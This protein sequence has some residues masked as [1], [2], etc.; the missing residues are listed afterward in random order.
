MKKYCIGLIVCS[1][2]FLLISFRTKEDFL[3]ILQ[4]KLSTYYAAHVP[5]KAHLFLNQPG[6]IPGDTLYYRIMLVQSQG[7][8]YIKGRQIVHLQFVNPSN[9]IAYQATVPVTDGIGS[10]QLRLPANLPPGGYSVLVYHNVMR[11]SKPVHLFQQPLVIHNKTTHT[12]SKTNKPEFFV[13]SGKLIA[14]VSN[15]MV[16][17]ASPMSTIRISDEA[18]EILATATCDN[19][20]W[21]N[22]YF[23]PSSGAKYYYDINQQARIELPVRSEEG[24]SMLVSGVNSGDHIRVAVQSSPETKPDESYVLVLSRLDQIFYGA[25]VDL[26]NKKSQVVSFAKKDLERGAYAITLFAESGEIISERLIFM[27]KDV[28]GL[29]ATVDKS[30]YSIREKVTV[31]FSLPQAT[32]SR[33]AVTV[34]QQDLFD[35]LQKYSVDLPAYLDFPSIQGASDFDTDRFMITQGQLTPWEEVWA[36]H[37]KSEFGFEPFLRLTGKASI[38]ST[39]APV[40]D[41]TRIEFFLQNDAAGYEFHTDANGHFSFPLLFDFYGDEQIH[42]FAESNGFTLQNILIE[43]EV[44]RF[45]INAHQWVNTSV[46]DPYYEFSHRRQSIIQSYYRTKPVVTE[47]PQWLNKRIEEAM[48]NADIEIKLSDYVLFPTMHETLLEI[49][50]DVKSRVNKNIVRVALKDENHDAPEDPLYII[51]GVLTD[52]SAY[53]LSLNPRDVVT[54]KVINTRQKLGIIGGIARNGVVLVDTT[55]PK[56]HAQIPPLQNVFQASG[57]TPWRKTRSL[58]DRVVPERE[59]DLRSTLYWNP[60]VKVSNGEAVITF[61]TA[62]NTGTFRLVAEGLTSTGIP[63][64]AESLFAVSFGNP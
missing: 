57:F 29:S 27:D 41:S 10:G 40:P 24:I 17:H 2:F 1:V 18:S 60:D 6:Y 22:V 44:V 26:K 35:S 61:Y 43:P 46:A 19:Q 59:P 62:N 12:L 42:Y 9:V 7:N 5:L 49:I 13:E 34:Y 14:G 28:P 45:D 8:R 55:I 20:G 53:F 52:N 63:L 31:K 33:L 4:E 38:R 47:Q 56:H 16:V 54:I 23:K 11:N 48:R 32:D 36:G 37:I 50:P 64:H 51:D 15:R 58:M 25:S 39:G 30:G 3:T 21:A